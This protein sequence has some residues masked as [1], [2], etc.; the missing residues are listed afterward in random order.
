MEPVHPVNPVDPV[1]PADSVD[2]VNPVSS[3]NS[4]EKTAAPNLRRGVAMHPPSLSLSA[5]QCRILTQRLST[6]PGS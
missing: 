5:R 3:V 4:V 2:P 6:I 1:D